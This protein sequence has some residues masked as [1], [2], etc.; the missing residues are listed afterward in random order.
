MKRS[1]KK[2]KQ[3]KVVLMF[4]L[5][6]AAVIV[7][8]MTFAWFSSKDEVTNR[9]S[10]SAN[11]NVLITETYT[12]E[13]DWIPG[14]K[15]DKE[16]GAV[17]TGT[18]DAYAK[19]G[20]INKL[21][22]K[23]ADPAG[24]SLSGTPDFTN[25]NLVRLGKLSSSDPNYG[26][27]QTA[28]EEA[29]ALQAGGYCVVK[30]GAPVTDANNN[31]FDSGKLYNATTTVDDTTGAI[32]V[33]ADAADGLYIFRREIKINKDT[34]TYTPDYA[35]AGYYVKDGVYYALTMQG[36]ATTNDS[37]V[38]GLTVTYQNTGSGET[39]STVTS[40]G[41]TL[42]SLTQKN[43]DDYTYTY[44]L[45]K[46]GTASADADGYVAADSFDDATAIKVVAH[47]TGVAANDTTN[48]VVV[49]LLLDGTNKANFLNVE[50]ELTSNDNSNV[51]DNN[52]GMAWFVYKKVLE[53][54]KSTGNL[55]TDVKLSKA[56]GNNTYFELDYDVNVIMDS[57]Q[58][59]SSTQ[60]GSESYDGASVSGWGV[61]VDSN[62]GTL[63]ETTP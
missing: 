44:S 10:A 63:T 2:R 11:Y 56:T 55:I 9:F 49:Y 33:S 40:T 3:K 59:I 23:I 27:D 53:S 29:I 57:V 17:N 4:T 13:K 50:T 8:G 15:V 16:V 22:T 62:T 58:A 52:K 37:T 48:D 54:G 31:G 18:V 41:V 51:V 32:T 12:P 42:R 35:Y 6:T 36:Q 61:T 1:E 47:L 60:D 39:V 21:T 30:A 20:F 7:G 28:Y 25:K 24:V 5:A 14:E 19:L 38:K 43:N 45:V 34:S 46:E 26:K